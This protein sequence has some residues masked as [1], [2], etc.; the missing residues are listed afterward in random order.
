[1]I[2]TG[3]CSWIYKGKA[4]SEFYPPQIKTS[5]GRLRYYSSHFRTVEVDATYYAIPP[6]RTVDCWIER[7]PPDFIFHIKVY[8]ALTGH[9]IEPRRLPV[10]VLRDI[11]VSERNKKYIFIRE[12]NILKTIA[13]I[14][15]EVIERLRLANKLGIIVFQYPPWFKYESRNIDYILFCKEIMKGFKIGIEFRHGSWFQENIYKSVL[16]FLDENGLIYITADEPQF[17]SISSVPFKP[18]LTG[19]TAYFRLHGRNRE[20]WFKKGIDA[21]YRYDYYYSDDEIAGFI[22]AGLNLNKTAKDVFIMFNNC[23]AGAAMK[24][25]LRLAD[26]LNQNKLF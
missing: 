26:F 1:M 11:P 6:K 16:K 18:A 9:S 8:G 2:Y 5:E 14:F 12:Q 10:E 22:E 24:N 19:D 13:D 7:T 20:N 15:K 17:N 21:T 3:S 25:A 23:H 4:F